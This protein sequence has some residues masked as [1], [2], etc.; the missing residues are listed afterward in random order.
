MQAPA[1]S[2]II[3]T[4]PCY[5]SLVGFQL[6]HAQLSVP[7]A[8][9]RGPPGS[10]AVS[11]PAASSCGS[12]VSDIDRNRTVNDQ[13]NDQSWTLGIIKLPRRCGYALLT[14]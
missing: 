5:V 10:G 1:L 6:L 8:L 3:R 12:I 2:R 13:Q 4:H 9:S 11:A 14:K 7:A